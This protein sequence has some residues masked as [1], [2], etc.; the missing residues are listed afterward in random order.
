MADTKITALTAIS[1]VDP[2][3]DVLPIVDVSDT[4]MAASGTT[5]KITSN[6]ILGAGGTATLASATITGDLTVDT[7][8]L[9]VDSTNNRVIV[10]HTSGSSAFQVTNAGAAGLEIQPTGFSSSPLILSYNR[11]GSAYTQLTLDGSTIVHALSGTTAMTLNSTGLGVGAT[12]TSRLTIGSGSFSTASANT[13]A[14]YTAATGLEVLSDSYY[15]GN[16][17]G[18]NL[19]TITSSGNVGV[20]VTPS[21]WVS[22]SPAVQL[23]YNSSIWAFTDNSL[24]LNQNA[25]FDGAW[26]YINSSSLASSNYYQEGGNHRWRTAAAGTAGNAI[27]WTTP[28]S[29]DTSGNLLVARTGAGLDNTSGV[30]IGQASIGMQ[31]E[32]NATQIVVNRTTSDGT[33]VDL[34][35]N[36]SSVGNI[37]VTTSGATFNSTSDYRLKE[38][39]APLNGGLAR[40]NALKPSVYKWKSNGSAGEGFLAHELAEV[41]PAAVNGEKD[42]VNDDGSIKAQSIDMSRVVPILV[43]AIKELTARVQ[44]LEAR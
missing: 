41:V 20:G 12:P 23:K 13:T 10:G 39:V 32:G 1:T 17:T 38:L 2:A 4:T 31:T 43:A 44:T 3:V 30:T 27:T 19:V 29:L 8:T 18:G 21:A 9:K 7:S 15:F 22:G 42:A 37:S 40:V 24:Q 35:R 28:M 36:N 16:R 5:K 26:K 33:I 6:Q 34:R 25:Y 14:M 11:S